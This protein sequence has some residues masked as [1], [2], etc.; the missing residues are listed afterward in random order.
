MTKTPMTSEAAH[1]LVEKYGVE[2]LATVVRL[3][4]ATPTIEI[5]RGCK[6]IWSGA[7]ARDGAERVTVVFGWADNDVT[8]AKICRDRGI[9]GVAF[10]WV[11]RSELA[12]DENQ[13]VHRTDATIAQLRAAG[14]WS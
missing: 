10:R 8:L 4:E 7:E 3:A 14:D 9:H 6:A 2:Q 5:H 1:D 13:S 12:Y 11:K